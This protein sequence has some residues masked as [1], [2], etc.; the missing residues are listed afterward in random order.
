VDENREFI[1]SIEKCRKGRSPTP[2]FGKKG[3]QNAAKCGI[4][5]RNENERR[6]A[7][8]TGASR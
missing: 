7:L 2:H 1:A 4:I 5:E 6:R 3:L 8:G